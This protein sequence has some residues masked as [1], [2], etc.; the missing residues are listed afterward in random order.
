MF[1]FAPNGATS[2]L[3]IPCYKDFAATELGLTE[4]LA[5]WIEWS[6]NFPQ[7]WNFRE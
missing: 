1:G 4:N 2:F 6:N 5:A 7:V 3:S